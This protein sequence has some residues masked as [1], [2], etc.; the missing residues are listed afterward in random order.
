MK[1]QVKFSFFYGCALGLFFTKIFEPLNEGAL[2]EEAIDWLSN[3]IPSSL[4]KSIA[5]ASEVMALMKD[6][7][8]SAAPALAPFLFEIASVDW[9]S[10]LVKF[11]YWAVFFN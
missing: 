1:E 10:T 2:E 5:S 3:E 9:F 7:E 6:E 8:M 11:T 4:S